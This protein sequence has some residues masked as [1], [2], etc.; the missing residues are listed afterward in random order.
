MNNKIK[1]TVLILTIITLLVSCNFLLVAQPS[2]DKYYTSI[3]IEWELEDNN[4]S[5][6]YLQDSLEYGFLG[7]Y[8]SSSYGA[9]SVL[10]YLNN[11]LC[12]PTDSAGSLV[13]AMIMGFKPMFFCDS[14]ES[15]KHPNLSIGRYRSVRNTGIFEGS[16]IEYFNSS[17][18]RDS[19]NNFLIFFIMRDKSS[20]DYK[21]IAI[22]DM[23]GPQEYHL[24]FKVD[25]FDFKL[26]PEVSYF[27]LVDIK[28]EYYPSKIFEESESGLVFYKTLY[29]ISNHKTSLK[30]IERILLNSQ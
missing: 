29:S 7:F 6:Q 25:S 23:N 24:T 16:K 22:R 30:E 21:L 5:Y 11:S 18:Y 1:I 20:A 2:M 4:S 15:G 13:T 8:E 14:F 12:C 26:M 17:A 27:D 19:E 28:S 10:K 9:D 3:R